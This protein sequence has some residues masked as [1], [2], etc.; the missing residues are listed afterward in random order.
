MIRLSLTREKMA[1][2]HE[3]QLINA[4]WWLWECEEAINEHYGGCDTIDAA[5]HQATTDFM[6][7]GRCALILQPGDIVMFKPSEIPYGAPPGS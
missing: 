3:G 6:M 7:F 2:M 4:G 5:I 1:C